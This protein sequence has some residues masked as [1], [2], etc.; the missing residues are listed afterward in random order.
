MNTTDIIYISISNL[1]IHVL[2]FERKYF[3]SVSDL[4]LYYRATTDGR[5]REEKSERIVR[6][7]HPRHGLLEGR[8]NVRFGMEYCVNDPRKS[9]AEETCKELG[10]GKH[11]SSSFG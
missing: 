11:G 10:R 3:G 6:Q 9:V 4:C 2:K 5:E 1:D 8:R 7:N